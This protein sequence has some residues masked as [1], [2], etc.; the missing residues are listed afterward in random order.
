MVFEENELPKEVGP[1]VTVLLAGLIVLADRLASQAD[2]VMAS[3][4]SMV[5]GTLDSQDPQKWIECQYSRFTE[6]VKKQVGVYSPISNPVEVILKGREPRPLQ[7]AALTVRD[8]IWFAMAA[9]GNGKT[10]AALLRHSTKDERLLFLL[11]HKRR[12]MR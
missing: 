8:G 1:V 9:T 2:S 7:S 12:R 4:S 10:E 3:Q 5:S 6:V 11:L